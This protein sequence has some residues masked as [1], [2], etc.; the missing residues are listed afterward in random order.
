MI[1][2]GKAGIFFP[3]A[4]QRKLGRRFVAVQETTGFKIGAR[5]VDRGGQ[6]G[7]IPCDD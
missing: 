6:A 3:R 5:R 4:C 7:N 2:S 1:R